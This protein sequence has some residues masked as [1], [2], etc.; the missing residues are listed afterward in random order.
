MTRSG[1]S[2]QPAVQALLAAYRSTTP[3]DGLPAGSQPD[4]LEDAYRIQ[5]AF[6]AA[7][8]SPVAGFKI[9]AASAASQALVGASGPFVARVFADRLLRSPAAIAP[10]R[11]FS[12]AVEAELAFRIGCDVLPSE[13]GRDRAAVIGCVSAAY[14]AVEICDNRFTDWRRVGLP[15]ILA[16][17]GFFGALV[18]GAPIDGWASRDLGQ[19][20]ATMTIAGVSRGSGVCAPVLGDPLDGVT[21]LLNTL[22]RHGVTVQAGAVI[23][24]GTWTG[25]HAVTAGERAVATFAGLGPVEIAF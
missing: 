3:I 20:H 2:P 1:F 14:T 19:T 12:P 10:G 25:L 15:Q 23:A 7:Y 8:S 11:F 21:W 17:N 16:D 4:D 5:E 13:G 9:G 6:A 18:L 24:I 22:G